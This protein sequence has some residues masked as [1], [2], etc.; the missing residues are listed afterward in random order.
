MT[1]RQERK[2]TSTFRSVE[3]LDQKLGRLECAA[4]A[5]NL[6]YEMLSVDAGRRET[7]RRMPWQEY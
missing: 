4:V 3:S 6:E 5:A 7:E 1:S 2:V